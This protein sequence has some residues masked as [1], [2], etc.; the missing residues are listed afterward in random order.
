M[1]KEGLIDGYTTLLELPSCPDRD[2]ILNNC[3]TL[4]SESGM[5]LN[6]L[7]VLNQI[8]T[9]SALSLNNLALVYFS[10]GEHYLAS[11]TMMEAAD[12]G[13]DFLVRINQELMQWV[14]K[15]GGQGVLA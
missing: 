15:I 1:R 4:Y 8:S 12:E 7:A 9:S 11:R 14:Y 13:E 2:A 6:A 5:F 10:L 3:A